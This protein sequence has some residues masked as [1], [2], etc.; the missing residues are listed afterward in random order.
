MAEV[1]LSSQVVFF[2]SRS[3]LERDQHASCEIGPE[4]RSQWCPMA[5]AA[6]APASGPH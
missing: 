1:V 4:A 3:R 6:Y 5:E 2:Y